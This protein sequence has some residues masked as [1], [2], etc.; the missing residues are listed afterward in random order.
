MR[1]VR[2]GSTGDARTS[3]R[4]RE[5]RGAAPERRRHQRRRGRASQ[6]RREAR[7]RQRAGADDP[8]R[9]V[10][11]HDAGICA[12]TDDA[13]TRVGGDAPGAGVRGVRRDRLDRHAG[14]RRARRSLGQRP[15]EDGRDPGIDCERRVLGSQSPGGR[16]GSPPQG[17]GTGDAARATGEDGTQGAQVDACG[18]GEARGGGGPPHL[19]G[20]ATGAAG[21]A[22]RGQRHP[23]AAAAGG[24]A[25]PEGAAAGGRP[26]LPAAPGV[27]G[28]AAALDD[29]ASCGRGSGAWRWATVRIAARADCSARGQARLPGGARPTRLGASRLT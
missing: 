4:R 22:H 15:R 1:R 23:R 9:G 21:P 13:A 27:R 6:R 2:A 8:A 19:R 12:G 5:R 24:G 7:R 25:E 29:R 18:S 16:A 3:R 28:P 17:T 10:G 11:R 14:R 26:P 20:S